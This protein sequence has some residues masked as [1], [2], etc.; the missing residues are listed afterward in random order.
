MSSRKHSTPKGGSGQRVVARLLLTLV[1]YL[2]L[3]VVLRYAGAVR[4]PV[5]EALGQWGLTGQ[6]ARFV[7][8]VVATVLMAAV[9]ALYIIASRTKVGGGTKITAKKALGDYAK[10]AAVSLVMIGAVVALSVLGGGVRYIGWGHVGVV[11]LVAVMIIGMLNVRE[12]LLFRGWMMGEMRE[13]LPTWVAVAASS[14]LFGLAHVFNPH[15]TALALVNLS[16]LGA[17]WALCVLKTGSLWMAMAMH[18]F[19]NFAQGKI[20]GMAVS[21]GSGTS[22]SVWQFEGVAGGLWGTGAF[23]LEGNLA[24]TIVIVVAL[25][26]VVAT[27]PQKKRMIR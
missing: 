13:Y 15:V 2:G 26:V 14:L 19:W 27:N 21:G 16:L 10:G 17:L 6:E 5:V 1:A 20:A 9:V 24:T 23:G 18:S 7:G 4:G 8:S 22:S 12:E 25:I 11:E 3:Q